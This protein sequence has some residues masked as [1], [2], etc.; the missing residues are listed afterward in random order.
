MIFGVPSQRKK[1]EEKYPNTAVATLSPY[2]G[3]GT[4]RTIALN[5]K[6]VEVLGLPEEGARVA[7]SFTD[8]I[9]ILNADQQG[10][11]S[12]YALRV[13]KTNSSVS[14]KKT[15]EYISTQLNLNNSVENEFSLEQSTTEAGLTVFEFKAMVENEVKDAPEVENIVEDIIEDDDTSVAD[16]NIET[17]EV[18]DFPT[19]TGGA[20][21]EPLNSEAPVTADYNDPFADT[22]EAN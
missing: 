10:V 3:K 18:K 14:D 13:G 5:E 20:P 8:G 7:F 12:V 9:F 15:Y 22:V 1:K 17:E 21:L 19:E 11:P 6:A 16:E 2:R 4:S